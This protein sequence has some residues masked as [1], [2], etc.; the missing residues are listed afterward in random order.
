MYK[1]SIYNVKVRELDNGDALVYNTYTGAFAVMTLETQ[2]TY[3]E[4]ESYCGLIS[5][6]CDNP[7][8]FAMQEY[9]YIVPKNI[10]ELKRVRDDRTTA[11]LDSS[12]INLTIAPTMQCN[13]R[14]PYC[15]EYRS[16]IHMDENTENLLIEFLF[17]KYNCSKDLSHI[18]VTWYGGEPL[19]N[20]S[21]LFRLS[22]KLIEFCDSHGID[23]TASIVTNGVLLDFNTAKLL[24]EKHKVTQAQ[25]TI[26][27]MEENHNKRRILAS[28]AGSFHTIIENINNIKGF[29]PI[30]VRVN[31][32]RENQKDLK[33]MLDYFRNDLGWQENPM[34][35]LAPVV[36]Y[37]DNCSIKSNKCFESSAFASVDVDF[38]RYN[39]EVNKYWDINLAYPE[40]RRISCGAECRNNYVV[41]PA[42]NLYTCWLLIN[43]VDKSCGNLHESFKF[44]SRYDEWV[45]S[46]LPEDCDDCQY[47]PVC[48]G[49]CA[50]YRI[51]KGTGP[52]CSHTFYSYKDKLEL[53]YDHF[54]K[55]RENL[56]INTED[57]G[58]SDET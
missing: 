44:N 31:V 28:G 37:T 48:Q 30:F 15:Y 1:K 5:S 24:V 43:Q 20:K 34:V 4:I 54:I 11:R 17:D 46:D 58:K 23:Y 42:G 12:I 50:F 45:D 51:D 38:T 49:G 19:V 33:N 32:D 10:D 39:Y 14:C 55:N 18:N 8:L 52:A 9:G 13:M 26:D 22:R 16:A 57:K 36:S 29:L 3:R 53:A 47:L 25:I 7:N 21:G 2:K 41:D 27:G 6:E 40:P 35:Y 56:N